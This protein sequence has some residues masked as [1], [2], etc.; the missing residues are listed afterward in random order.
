VD[1]EGVGD[2]VTAVASGAGRGRAAKGRRQLCTVGQKYGV[3]GTDS[4]VATASAKALAE[5]TLTG[6]SL[7]WHVRP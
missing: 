3:G 6:S 7:D 5:A 1:S 4:P 2:V